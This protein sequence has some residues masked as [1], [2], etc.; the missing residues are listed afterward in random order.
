MKKGMTRGTWLTLCLVVGSCATTSATGPSA[1]TFVLDGQSL[2]LVD[3]KADVDSMTGDAVQAWCATNGKLDQPIAGRSADRRCPPGAQLR[4]A[5]RGSRTLLEDSLTRFARYELVRDRA[6]SYRD[7]RGVQ[8]TAVVVRG[9]TGGSGTFYYVGDVVASKGSNLVLLGDRVAV[10]ALR[11][12]QGKIVVDY[13]DRPDDVPMANPPTV[14]KRTMF[15][16]EAGNLV[17]LK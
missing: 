2:P 3:G 12:E 5:K 11:Y 10:D 1:A 4:F 7:A 14:A 6:T 17:Q 9:D 13:R 15:R 8:H 16:A